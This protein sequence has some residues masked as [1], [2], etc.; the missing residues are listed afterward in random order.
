MNGWIMTN[1]I[2]FHV[3]LLHIENSILLEISELNRSWKIVC[4]VQLFH[5]ENFWTQPLLEICLSITTKLL[6]IE[7]STFIE[8]MNSWF[9]TDFIVCHMLNYWKFLN[10]FILKAQALMEIC[11]SYTELFHIE[12]STTTKHMN[13]LFTTDIIVCHILN[14]SI[15]KIQVLLEISELFHIENS[16]WLGICLLYI[17]LFHI[18]STTR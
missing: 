10:Y 1:I 13:S 9:T 2:V 15:L 3:Q 5:I 14:Y 7:N 4:H 17:E 16:T 12:N 6:H 11:L 18:N 8:N